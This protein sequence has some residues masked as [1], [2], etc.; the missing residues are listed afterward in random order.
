MPRELMPPTLTVFVSVWVAGSGSA[1]WGRLRVIWVVASASLRLTSETSHRPS[2]GPWPDT[3][4]T[5]PGRT[6]QRLARAVTGAVAASRRAAA[7]KVM[8]RTP[9]GPGG[10]KHPGVR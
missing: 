2:A 9:R 4:T 5:S 1:A 10:H 6:D 8:D 7:S 3:V